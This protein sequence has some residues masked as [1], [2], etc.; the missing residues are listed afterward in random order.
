[1]VALLSGTCRLSKRA[2]QTLLKDGFGVDV[3]LG[4]IGNIERKL[5]RAM[6]SPVEVARAHVRG[7]PIVHPDETSWREATSAKAVDTLINFT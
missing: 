4:S 1:M 5:S 3:G 7:S 6:E 2:T